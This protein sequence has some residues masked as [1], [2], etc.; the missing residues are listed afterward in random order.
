MGVDDS[1]NKIESF[2]T[3]GGKNLR[4]YKSNRLI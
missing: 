2:V 3:I 1:T 4:L